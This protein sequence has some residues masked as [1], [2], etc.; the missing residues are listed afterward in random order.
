MSFALGKR[1]PDISMT[2]LPKPRWSLFRERNSACQAPENVRCISWYNVILTPRSLKAAIK[3]TI[4]AARHTIP[5]SC[6]RLYE[7]RI[8]AALFLHERSNKLVESISRLGPWPVVWG[9]IIARLPLLS[10]PCKRRLSRC[11]EICCSCVKRRGYEAG[12]PLP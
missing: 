11:F 2:I 4:Q 6:C 5:K 12:P 10:L 7:L 8:R 9:L 1:W 3:T